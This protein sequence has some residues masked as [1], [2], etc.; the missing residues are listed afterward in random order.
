MGDFWP[1]WLSFWLPTIIGL[2]GL[3]VSMPQTATMVFLE[4]KSIERVVG[5]SVFVSYRIFDLAFGHKILSWR[6]FLVS[7]AF[8]SLSFL[9][10]FLIAALTTPGLWWFVITFFSDHT[11]ASDDFQRYEE[12][13]ITATLAL[14]V[15]SLAAEFLYVTKSRLILRSLRIHSSYLNLAS[16]IFLDITTTFVLFV[17]VT[18]LTII[19][20]LNLLATIFSGVDL[21]HVNFNVPH[22]A[23]PPCRED[24]YSRAGS[25][26]LM[27]VS[28]ILDG[29]FELL[30]ICLSQIISHVRE[31]FAYYHWLDVFP[32]VDMSG[33]EKFAKSEHI[34]MSNAVITSG[35]T[36]PMT[37]MLATAFSTTVWVSVSAL[38]LIL[39]RFLCH[40]FV[41][42]NRLFRHLHNHPQAI[43]WWGTFPSAV[44]FILGG[45]LHE[46]LWILNG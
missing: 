15:S 14:I 41:V 9:L 7:S 18:P 33:V 43:F 23:C 17:M 31:S 25:D 26:N 19:L 8:S 1:A 3:Q 13:G 4:S 32:V 37:T 20:T 35:F 45:L 38:L 10:S 12:L 34:D 5:R 16:K 24:S 11:Y 36:Y 29:Y 28:N 44:V 2:I 39:S 40:T 27:D 42:A 22:I 6:A 30:T 21:H 46:L